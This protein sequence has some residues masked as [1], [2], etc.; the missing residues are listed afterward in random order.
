M[1]AE[2]SKE[3][4]AGI[5][6]VKMNIIINIFLIFV[7]TISGSLGAFFMKKCSGRM[8]KTSVLE[9]L[10]I[11]ELYAGGILYLIGACTNI[12]LL[13]KLPYTVVYPVTSV[14]YVW[15]MVIS[16]ILLK[17]KITVNKVAAVILI[18]LGVCCISLG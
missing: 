14:T 6:D 1:A 13:R 16:C 8:E 15:T 17:E 11:P 5:R 3:V 9:M 12:L 18:M 10:K 2:C 7:M 4:K